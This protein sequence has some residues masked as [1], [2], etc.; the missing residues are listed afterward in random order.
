MNKKLFWHW[1]ICLLLLTLYLKGE[2]PESRAHIVL[3]NEASN[4]LQTAQALE[5]NGDW[6][7]AVKNYQQALEKYPNQ[8]VPS[9]E[10]HNY[11]G[12][13]YLCHQI[14]SQLPPKGKQAYQ[15]IFD[16]AAHTLIE[17]FQATGNI[18]LL[19][20]VVDRYFYTSYGPNAL[21]LL[22]LTH[23]EK[24]DL[25]EACQ[26]LETLLDSIDSSGNIAPSISQTIV[27]YALCYSQLKR[28]ERLQSLLSLIVKKYPEQKIVYQNKFIS[29]VDFI[30]ILLSHIKKME[31]TPSNDWCTYGGNKTHN[32]LMGPAI[33]NLPPLVWSFRLP[34][35]QILPRTSYT[36]AI[37]NPNN[38]FPYFPSVYKDILYLKT[39]T[40]IYAFNLITLKETNEEEIIWKFN[41]DYKDNLFYEERML[42]P[43]TVA[44]DKVYAN[45]VA[46]ASSS[47]RRDI[48][49][50]FFLDVKFPLPNRA[51]FAFN[52]SSGKILWSIGGQNNFREFLKKASFTMPPIVEHNVLYTSAI[53]AEYDT[54]LPQHYLCAFNA[55]TGELYWKTFITSGLLEV[56]LFNNPA[57]EIIGSMLTVDDNSVYYCSNIGAITAVDKRSGMIKWLNKYQQND[58]PPTRN[59]FLPHLPLHWVNNPLI[60]FSVSPEKSILINTPLDSPFLYVL[61][62][63]TGEELWKWEGADLGTN[64]YVL[65]IKDN[66]LYLQ[67]ENSVICLNIAKEG[68]RQWIYT[69]Q[70]CGKGALTEQGLYLS[71]TNSLVILHPVSGKIIN[72]WDW[73]K[74]ATEPGNLLILDNILITTSKDTV[75]VFYDWS[76][77]EALFKRQLNENPNDAYLIQRIGITYLKQGKY[78]EAISTFKQVLGLAENNPD[79][80]QLISLLKN[81]LYR[82]YRDLANISN[83]GDKTEYIKYLESARQYAPN[84]RSTLEVTIDLAEYYSRLKLWSEAIMEYKL[85]IEKTPDEPYNGQPAKE[86]AQQQI[87]QIIK[88]TERPT[89]EKK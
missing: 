69:G 2:S 82:A 81:Y 79:A 62:P 27:D 39:D 68:K 41:Y 4:L 33:S 38:Y 28:T 87:N 8:L 61:D 77:I 30:R 73:A 63:K 88:Q 72:T 48:G 46:S 16:P 56:N 60:K 64:R 17:T 22:A 32:Q 24:G 5:K 55:S 54:D 65:G 49:W 25:D 19:K 53:Y 34:T 74:P 42:S 10:Y 71:T 43:I 21:S 36:G 78:T 89:Y 7:G 35:V 59:E 37:L 40:A 13:K 47:D 67:G 80:Q 3:S 83:K 44:E 52:S 20:E 70:F 57:R 1:L 6:I 84:R 75:N 85:L 11:Q 45:L 51:L 58:I 76:K 29:M 26:L 86:F 23:M 9:L 66:L 15:N 31:L 12:V 18:N 14:L 50:N